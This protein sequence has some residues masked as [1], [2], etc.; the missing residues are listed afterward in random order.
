MKTALGTTTINV[1]HVLKLHRACDPDVK[2]FVAID[3]KTR[4]ESCELIREI[5][6]TIAE[7][8]CC[9]RRGLPVFRARRRLVIVRRD[10]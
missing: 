4:V 9:R 8:A 10:E 3:E 6:V 7:V 1:P 5:G 2:I